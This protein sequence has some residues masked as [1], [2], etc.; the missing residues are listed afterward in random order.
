MTMVENVA[1]VRLNRPDKINAVDWAMLDEIGAVGARLKAD[2]AV[3]A[4]V[5][6]GAGR[7]FCAGLDL[8]EF[9]RMTAGQSLPFD[10]RP[11]GSA[12]NTAQRAVW[13][14]RELAVPVIAA[15]HGPALGAGLQIA[16]GADIRIVAPGARLG[17]LEVA[18][19]L[20]PDMAGT[21]LLPPLVGP[22]VAKEL[23]LTGRVVNGAEAVRLGLATRLAADPYASAMALAR[24]IAGRSPAAV[25]GTKRLI[26]M[27]GQVELAKALAEEERVVRS[28]I[29]TPDQIEAVL[30]TRHKRPPVF[31]DGGPPPSDLPCSPPSPGPKGDV[32]G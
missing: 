32:G 29:G 7:G 11:P 25:R 16:L 4:V 19:G 1:V 8:A 14:W 9:A 6:T 20:V 28:L 21:Q 13:V 3:R 12:I 15:V 31:T 18:W 22:D 10:D 27:A 26:D 17:L 5:L 24:E 23:V 2:R 30:A